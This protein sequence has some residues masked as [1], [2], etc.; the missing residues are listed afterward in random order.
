MAR[1]KAVVVMAAG[2]GT[3]MRSSRIKVLHTLAGRAVLDYPV[4]TA[5]AVGAD[6]VVVVVGHQR[7]QVRTHLADTFPDAPL[8]TVVQ[9]EQLGTGHAVL[10]AEAA[11]EGFDGWVYI[12]SGDVPLLPPEALTELD[13]AAGE[14]PVAVV[15]MRLDDPARY[16]RLVRDDE[17]LARIV[18]AADCTPEQLAIDE[19]NAGI[20]RVD[21]KVL[22]E[23]LRGLGT[24]N[25]QGE[26]YL[27]DLVHRGREAGLEVRD[28]VLE[29]DRAA[30]CS[31]INDRVDLAAAEGQLQARLRHALMVG[32][33]TLQDPASVFLHDTV[34]V[35][36]DTVLEPGVTLLGDTSIGRDCVVERGVRLT[37][38]QVADG[39]HLKAYTLAEHAVIDSGCQVGPFARLRE[40]T[41]LRER[42]KVG[43]FVETKKTELGVGAKA[44]HLTYLGDASVGPGSNIGAGTIT[45]NYDGKNKFRTVIG[46]GAFI[47]SDTQLVAPV[48]VGDGA[49]V[50]AGTTVTQTVPPGALAL[51]RSRQKNIPDWVER[52]LARER[53]RNED[54]D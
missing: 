42:V 17:G 2:L 13:A 11:L 54:K 53:A 34:Q 4:R 28:L 7:E 25:A 5:L 43:N 39:V 16:G 38:T 15:G 46:A 41:V 10:C 40:G 26:Y 35:G 31:G 27:T 24:L 44:S 47:G 22:F 12:L 29:G 30:W 48:K 19:V 21:S 1:D 52:R 45:C 18:E 51:S 9:D 37:D 6:P 23:M 36:A 8:A 50:G 20:Y 32:G 33:V 14:A 3:R 49:Y